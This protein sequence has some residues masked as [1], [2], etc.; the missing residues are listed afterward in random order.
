MEQKLGRVLKP[1]EVVHH[2]NDNKLDYS[3]DNLELKPSQSEHA[4]E[5]MQKYWKEIR[6]REDRILARYFANNKEGGTQ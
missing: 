5:H 2:I 4:R 3:E 1:G 6:D